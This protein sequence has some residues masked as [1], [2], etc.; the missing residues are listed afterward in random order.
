[1]GPFNLYVPT[2]ERSDLKPCQLRSQVRCR[3]DLDQPA[4]EAL[5]LVDLA[6][7]V[8]A[9]CVAVICTPVT[10]RCPPH[11]SAQLSLVWRL[12]GH[13]LVEVEWR[14][15]RP[16]PV[17]SGVGP[18][19]TQPDAML[20]PSMIAV[21]HRFVEEG[22]LHEVVDRDGLRSGEREVADVCHGRP[23]ERE[24]GGP[25]ALVPVDMS[26]FGRTCGRGDCQSGTECRQTQEEGQHGH[27][28]AP[29]VVAEIVKVFGA[30][31][32]RD[33]SF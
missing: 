24:V 20:V 23:H 21:S 13:P 7:E 14:P 4:P 29:D 32:I 33:R 1:M 15:V 8:D 6:H 9:M 25:I 22:V 18:A 30:V 5:L 27:A 26:L 3:S 10:A 17:F 31:V 16:G 12:I 28:I 11:F 19:Q 2:A